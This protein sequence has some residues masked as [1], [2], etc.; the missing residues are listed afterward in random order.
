MLVWQAV[1]AWRLAKRCAAFKMATSLCARVAILDILTVG[2]PR[3]AWEEGDHLD[4][5]GPGGVSPEAAAY[6][7]MH[8]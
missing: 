8:Q 6:V 7:S 2:L 4:G 3:E 5:A 1:M